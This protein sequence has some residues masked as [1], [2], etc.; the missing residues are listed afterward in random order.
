MEW[1]KYS[2]IRVALLH[3]KTGTGPCK[4]DSQ[5]VVPRPL[6]EGTMRGLRRGRV[7]ALIVQSKRSTGPPLFPLDRASVPSPKTR[8]TRWN[9]E[10]YAKPAL[11]KAGRRS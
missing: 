3:H 9:T 2:G 8:P 7:D 1:M 5:K 11:H 6:D 10:R 4:L